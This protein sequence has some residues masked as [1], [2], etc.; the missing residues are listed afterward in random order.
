MLYDYLTTHEDDELYRYVMIAFHIEKTI[1]ENGHVSRGVCQVDENH[2]LKEIT[3]RT[4][5]ENE[6]KKQRIH[7][8]TE[9]AGYRFRI[10]RQFL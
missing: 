4:R 3:E 6:E 1:T 5:I 8:M 7:W 9:Q 10:K 2:F